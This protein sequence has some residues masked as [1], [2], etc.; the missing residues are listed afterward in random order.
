MNS[1]LEK[2]VYYGW[3]FFKLLDLLLTW[4]M[5]SF[6]NFMALAIKFMTLY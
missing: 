5:T 1:L 6:I 4:S 2:A 3:G